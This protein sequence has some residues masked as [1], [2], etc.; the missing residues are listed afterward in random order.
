MVLNEQLR[1]TD[2]TTSGKK[3]KGKAAAG[4]KTGQSKKGKWEVSGGISGCAKEWAPSQAIMIPSFFVQIFVEEC[5]LLKVG[6][7]V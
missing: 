2:A 1:V 7:W 4:G 6:R 3:E 5:W